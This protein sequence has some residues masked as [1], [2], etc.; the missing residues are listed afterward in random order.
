MNLSKAAFG[1]ALGLTLLSAPLAFAADGDG[2]VAFRQQ[3]QSMAN[4]DGMISRK[5]FL[6]MMERKFDAMDRDR[7]GMLSIGELMR[8]FSDSQGQ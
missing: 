2:M 1:V 8:I 5:D 7:K 4:K 6:A 3:M